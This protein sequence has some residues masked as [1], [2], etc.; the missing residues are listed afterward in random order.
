[1]ITWQEYL[2][3]QTIEEALLALESAAG[4]TRPIGGGT[5]LLLEIQQGLKKPAHTLVDITRIRELQIL[6]LREDTLF[7]GAGL[8]VGRISDSPLVQDHAMAVAE[9]CR[10]IG[11]PQV[12]NTATLGGNV[13][14]ALP[15]ADGMIAL[16]AMDA[17]VET[18]SREGRQLR[19]LG[20]LFKGP[21]ETALHIEREIL[22]GFHLPLQQTGQ[23]SAFSRVMR[24]QGVALPI[25]N[26]AVWIERAGS[27]IKNIRIAFGPS[28]PVPIRATQV[29]DM[30][31]GKPWDSNTLLE[32]SQATRNS[33]HFRTSAMRATSGYRQYLSEVLLEEV[34]GKAWLRADGTETSL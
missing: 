9:A 5:D 31:R 1:M 32:A 24:P 10:L 7:I 4:T 19:P 12:R 25:L 8:A 16:L 22:V 23:A 34:I 17:A 11:G 27:I 26:L 13:A 18:A 20:S 3:P 30:L 6:E 15:A 21:G 14:H 29:E 28:G 2:L 33:I